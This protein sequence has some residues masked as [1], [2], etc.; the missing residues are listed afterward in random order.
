MA[1]R[2]QYE[3]MIYFME[4]QIRPLKNKDFFTVV[5][6]LMKVKGAIG[7]QLRNLKAEEKPATPESSTEEAGKATEERGKKV[8][9][10]ILEILYAEVKDDLISWFAD[11]CQVTPEDYMEL[12]LE[13]TVDVVESLVDASFFTRAWGLFNKITNSGAG[14]FGKS[15]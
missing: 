3:R 8:I 10:T 5:E 13:T 12:P 15:S 4:S 1:Y 2:C 14:F 6:M 7:T 9:G 11:L